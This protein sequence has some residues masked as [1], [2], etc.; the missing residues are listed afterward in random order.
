MTNKFKGKKL[1]LNPNILF[2]E[3]ENEGILIDLRGKTRH[4]IPNESA[5]IVLNLLTKE[6]KDAIHFEDL[7]KHLVE[8]YNIQAAQAEGAVDNL[9]QVLAKDGLLGSASADSP[10]TGKIDPH[11]KKK[12]EKVRGW[13]NP[14]ARPGTGSGVVGYVV[15]SYR[16]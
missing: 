10:P 15:T 1:W 16:P 14:E 7:Q 6:E 9:C 11:I 5:S 8:T 4:Y 3:T 12:K 2:V 13:A